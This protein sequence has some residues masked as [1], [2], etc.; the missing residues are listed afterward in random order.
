[1]NK[2]IISMVL[3][4][5]IFLAIGVNVNAQDNG[6]GTVVLPTFTP[7]PTPA[8]DDYEPDS[9][10]YPAIYTGK[11]FRSFS[12]QSDIDYVL[13][14]VK[15]GEV[16]IFTSGLEGE[17]DTYIEVYDVATNT[18]LERDDDSGYGLSSLVQF[19]SSR[20]RDI[21]III[22]NKSLGYGESVLYDLTIIQEENFTPT[23]IPA[24]TNTPV[25]QPTERPTQ[26]PLPTYT[27]FPTPIPL[28]TLPPETPNPSTLFHLRVE[29]FTDADQD[30]ILD[31]GE[32]VDG[33]MV[34]VNAL[35]LAAEHVQ[36]G[37]TENGILILEI[38]CPHGVDVA[39]TL[40][41]SIPYLQETQLL[42]GADTLENTA[43]V[44][45]ILDTP[46]LPIQ[47]P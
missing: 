36:G 22:H 12:P 11:M 6:G 46:L 25:P 47:M 23:P 44:Q 2:R 32:G 37:Y 45:F 17:A 42:D 38:I 21:L 41:I 7:S 27:P 33:M 28:P 30:G 15:P 20:E 26:T 8:G 24:A 35:D 19:V 5:G 29:V 13:Y 39:N 40:E 4:M 34:D 14:H 18:L 1:M 16:Q 3:L 9:L 43:V 31:I 10:E